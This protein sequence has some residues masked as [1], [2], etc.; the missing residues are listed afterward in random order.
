M[1]LRVE[2]ELGPLAA[3]WDV[4]LDQAPR[5]SV[6]LR[7][8]W[9]QAV[10]T[11]TA[12]FVLVFDGEKLVGGCPLQEVDWHGIPLLEFIGSGPLE[13]DHL[14]VVV[15]AGFEDRVRDEVFAWL[16]RRGSRVVDLR[17]MN[18]QAVML[19]GH[20][21]AT[22]QLMQAAPFSDLS[23]GFANF[24]QARPKSLRRDVRQAQRRMEDADVTFRLCDASEVEGAL[25]ALRNMHAQQW[26]D[27][28]SFMAGWP[29]FRTA[30]LAGFERGE[31]VVGQATMPNGEPIAAGVA[32]QCDSVLFNYQS[33]RSKDS[34]WTG[35]GTFVDAELMQCNPAAVEVDWLRGTERYKSK[36]A[37]GQRQLY[38]LRLTR[39]SRAWLAIQASKALRAWRANRAQR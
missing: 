21:G 24:M 15:A 27:Q 1:K 2:S 16:D 25:D 29:R 23:S 37:T 7:S 31:V 12:Q 39:G 4:L 26:G 33:G 20:Q 38:R 36:W 13:A 34:Q 10:A 32:L 5:P 22:A 30:A 35:S 3:R 18:E 19:S 28:S 9:L 6:F 8:W 11:G 14:D 17:G